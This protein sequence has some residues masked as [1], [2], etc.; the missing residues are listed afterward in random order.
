MVRRFFVRATGRNAAGIVALTGGFRLEKTVGLPYNTIEYMESRNA[1][2]DILLPF[3]DHL[4]SVPGVTASQ[5]KTLKEFIQ[6]TPTSENIV[7]YDPNE[8]TKQ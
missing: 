7:F 2:Q 1:M 8:K 3:L 6:Y 5:V 4:Q